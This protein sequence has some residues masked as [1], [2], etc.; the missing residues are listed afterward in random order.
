MFNT[1]SKVYASFDVKENFSGFNVKIKRPY[2]AFCD[3]VNPAAVGTS[4]VVYD[5]LSNVTS[6]KKNLFSEIPK[7]NYAFIRAFQGEIVKRLIRLNNS[8]ESVADFY[9]EGYAVNGS[10]YEKVVAINFTSNTFFVKSNVTEEYYVIQ[11][12]SLNIAVMLD[13]NFTKLLNAQPE[14][15]SVIIKMQ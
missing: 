6:E 2:Y 14:M 3:E 7:E 8:N 1:T 13:T 12:G 5:F 15:R 10:K 4:D 9:F 11:K